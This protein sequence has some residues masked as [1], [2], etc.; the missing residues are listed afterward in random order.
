[1]EPRSITRVEKAVKTAVETLPFGTRGPLLV[2]LSGGPDS[3]AL[4][5]IL[6]R[7]RTAD[8][9]LGY[10]MVAAH[11]NHGLRGAESDR[12][13][14]FVRAL[15][16]KMGVPIVVER[17]GDMK[18]R[19]ANAEER[20]RELRYAFLNRTADRL[21]AEVIATAHHADDQA[22]TVL[23]R[24]LRG[25][26]M[27]GLSAMAAVGPGRLFRPLLATTRKEVLAYLRAIDADY[28]TDSSNSSMT[29]LRN[30]MRRELI[31]MLE[32]DYAPRLSRRLVEL[33]G[34]MGELNEFVTAQ[35]R[36][37][38]ATRMANKNRI[39][40]D[41]FSS[42]HPA[43]AAVLLREFLRDTIG[44]LR[45]LGRG[46]V[47]AM[48]RLCTCPDAGSETVVL[49]QGWIFRREYGYARLIRRTAKIDSPFAIA[50]KSEGTTLVEPAQFTLLSRAIELG[51]GNDRPSWKTA[52][53]LE[54][55]F[56][57]DQIGNMVA[58]S[59][60][61]GDR[62]RV[63]GSGGR[64]KVQDVFV[65]KKLPFEC[66]ARWPI[67]VWGEE[68]VWIPNLVRSSI[69]T[70]T[71]KTQKVLYLRAAP[72]ANRTSLTLLAN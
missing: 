58:R 52:D 70:V 12:D 44:T 60:E 13:E 18:I 30:R 6:L 8:P 37:E 32:G 66:R 54:A 51:D 53:A 41:G 26:G 56:D 33:A 20:A 21:G 14:S 16:G 2:A 38:L 35:A 36:A 59:F 5:H 65:D 46:N 34:E 28:V 29:F 27:A 9:D 43:L 69:A 61:K 47:E 4:L 1:M 17:V 67:V 49:P 64:R 68:I 10:D 24:L 19:R 62:I 3:V 11:L 63:F 57:A 31:P 40:L 72:C 71:S 45:H 55:Y 15:C 39:S 25:S 23:L 48:R 50:L 42:L 7:L 22:E